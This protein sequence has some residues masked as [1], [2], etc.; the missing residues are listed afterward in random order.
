MSLTSDDLADIKQLLDVQTSRIEVR[1]DQMDGRLDKMDRRLD[2]MDE[3]FDEQDAKLDE[4]LNAVGADM[5]QQTVQLD[6]HE[7]R[8]VRLE[9]KIA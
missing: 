9:K 5:N 1:L 8:I 4:I 6:D 7:S 3:R 2:K